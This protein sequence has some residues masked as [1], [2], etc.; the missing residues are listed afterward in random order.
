MT[1]GPRAGTLPTRP[2]DGPAGERK[3]ETVRWTRSDI[4]VIVFDWGG[5]LCGASRERDVMA[6]CAEATVEAARRAGLPV[7]PEAVGQLLSLGRDYASR[8]V[9]P[10]EYREYDVRAIL[11]EWLRGVCG[12]SPMDGTLD[13]ILTACWER[14]IGC[15]DTLAGVPQ[16]MERLAAAGYVLGLMSNTAAPAW[17]CEKELNRLGLDR[18]L[19]FAEFSSRLGRRKPHASVYKA[20]ME[21][22][23]THC[24]RILPGEVLFVGDTPEA[25]VAG[26][27]RAGMR[28]ALVGSAVL[29]ADVRPDLQVSAVPDLLKHL[30]V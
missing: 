20:V 22:A 6:G 21:H 4:R 28:T 24:P 19:R 18:H 12:P 17:A 2:R 29:P 9:E 16:M 13:G 15:L 10:P 14:W 11:A 3:G 1:G 30:E 7:R 27:A 5:T 8:P 25:D 26:P 23:R